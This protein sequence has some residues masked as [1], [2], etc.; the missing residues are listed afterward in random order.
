MN[1]ALDFDPAPLHRKANFELTQW[2]VIRD[3][4]HGNHGDQHA[5]LASL[6]QA[7]WFPLYAYLRGAGS[8][9]EDAED[10]TQGFLANLFTSDKL[11]TINPEKGKF[12]NFLL[13]SLKNYVS[14]QDRS[15]R[16]K[17]RGGCSTL[18]PI[19]A[20]TAEEQLSHHL[21]IE[22]TPDR[23]Y[24]QQ[25]GRT[26]LS[27]VHSLLK[28]EF[29]AAGKESLF[30]E[31]QI[32]LAGDTGLPSYELIATQC[33]MNKTAVGMSVHRMRRR[34]AELLRAEIS[35]TVNSQAEIDEEILF[36]YRTFGNSATSW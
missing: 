1:S 3:A 24:A 7:Y 16:A 14:N 12:R 6:C 5:A 32:Y 35:K 15:A 9:P 33:G 26:L 4:V 17:K 13:A 11:E 28:Q 23:L 36:L 29:Q 2:S 19:N 34:F 22:E 31:L 20:S 18:I 10:T 25:W 30:A 21:Q 8:S 27:H